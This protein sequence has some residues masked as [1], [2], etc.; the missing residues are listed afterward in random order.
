MDRFFVSAL[1]TALLAAP[2][3]SAHAYENAW[4]LLEAAFFG[5]KETWFHYHAFVTGVYE[6]HVVSAQ[7]YKQDQLVCPSPETTPDDR[8]DAV[9]SYL[10]GI[11]AEDEERMTTPARA[12]V[13][14]GLLEGFPCN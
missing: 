6:G 10:V 13:F 11:A 8:V 4:D 5:E 3:T 2:F 1:L 12:I 14:E 9:T 7:L